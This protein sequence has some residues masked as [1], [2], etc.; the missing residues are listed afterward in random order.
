MLRHLVHYNQR[1]RRRIDLCRHIICP[2]AA[3]AASGVTLRR[4]LTRCEAFSASL[5]ALLLPPSIRL[6]KRYFAQKRHIRPKKKRSQH[7]IH[8]RFT[9][10]DLNAS[11]R[12]TEQVG[13]FRPPLT[14]PYVPFV[15]YGGFSACDW[16]RNPCS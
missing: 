14:P 13:G 11:A 5:C 9:I 6:G 10:Y 4:H 1:F 2:S 12:C 3:H 8:L 16:S 7:A 15:A